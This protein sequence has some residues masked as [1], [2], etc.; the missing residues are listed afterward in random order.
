MTDQKQLHAGCSALCSLALA[1]AHRGVD[2]T[3]EA[4]VARYPELRDAS[5]AWADA[6]RVLRAYR[7]RAK[8]LHLTFD[9]LHEAQLPAVIRFRSG[10]YAM[11][12][13]SSDAV[14]FFVD[15]ARGAP[16]ASSACQFGGAS[17]GARV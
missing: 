15:P 13:V 2:V 14:V 7:Y 16:V 1:L 9:E 17:G 11:L 10:A 6:R 5:F 3:Q 12:G 8:L 4:L